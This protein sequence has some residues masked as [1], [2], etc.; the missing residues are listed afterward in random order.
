MQKASGRYLLSGASGMLGTAIRR[1]FTRRELEV[2]TLVRPG[3]QLQ[4]GQSVRPSASD[5]PALRSVAV[6]LSG[7]V[8]WNPTA[9]QAVPHPELLECT[10]AAIHLSGANLADHRWTAEYKN[11]IVSSRVESTRALASTLAGLRQR[12]STML[13]ASAVGIYGNRGDEMLDDSSAPGSGFLADLCRQWE[14]AAQPAVDAGIRVVH[15][16]FGVVI[17][18]RSNPGSLARVY[19]IFGLGLG[20]RLGSG[21]QWMSWIGLSDLAAAVFFL[22][23]KTEISGAVNVTAP[24]PVTNAQ[25]TV[26]LAREMHRPAF[27]PVP[28]AALRLAF[29]EMSDEALL[30]STRAYPSRLTAAGFQFEHPTIDLALSAGLRRL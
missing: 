28:A 15:L 11:K 21:R 22:L 24:N 1:E 10:D 8:P 13:V 20:G 6:A 23:Q 14:A 3:R 16:R 9:A 18:N 26:A 25:F 19:R 5:R 29:G 30:A 2:L 7:E 12:P 4:R 27:L 17:G